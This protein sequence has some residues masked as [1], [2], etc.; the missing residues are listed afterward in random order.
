MTLHL[1]GG[2][3]VK[4]QSFCLARNSSTNKHSKEMQGTHLAANVTHV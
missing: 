3:V 2:D 1:V 4:E